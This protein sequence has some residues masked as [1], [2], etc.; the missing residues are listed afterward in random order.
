MSRSVSINERDEND[1]HFRKLYSAALDL[2]ILENRGGSQIS[3]KPA[4]LSMSYAAAM[5]NYAKNME[6]DSRLRN[7]ITILRTE[8][9]LYTDV[10][11][12]HVNSRIG[13]AN[14][15]KMLCTVRDDLIS[16]NAKIRAAINEAIKPIPASG[17]RR[18]KKQSKRS[19]RKRSTRKRSTRKRSTRKRSTQKAYHRKRQ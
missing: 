8:Y 16:D 2:D 12:G 9:P 14:I 13:T 19:T 3:K 11:V 10:M 18:H 17:G 6:T 15:I 5:G 7:V 4:E 1:S